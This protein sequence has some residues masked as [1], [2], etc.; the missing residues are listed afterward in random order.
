MNQYI[1]FE[2]V[3]ELRGRGSVINGVYPRLVQKR[4]P[5]AGEPIPSERGGLVNGT[6]T[7]WAT[8]HQTP[9]SKGIE[10]VL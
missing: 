3:V 9:Y 6:K 10:E 5:A 7:I 8:I 4:D 2:E 1:F